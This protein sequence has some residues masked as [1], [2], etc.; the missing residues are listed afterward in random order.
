MEATT[1]PVLVLAGCCGK[2]ARVCGTITR[3]GSNAAAV[4]K[5]LHSI[6]W[7]LPN[8][9]SRCPI[10]HNADDHE[11]SHGGGVQHGPVGVEWTKN[12]TS[13]S[14]IAGPFGRRQDGRSSRLCPLEIS[15][16]LKVGFLKSWE[17]LI[18]L[19]SLRWLLVHCDGQ[20]HNL[21]FVFFQAGKFDFCLLRVCTMNSN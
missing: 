9:R 14:P 20:F 16:L 12:C 6:K 18:R 5:V 4:P 21:P 11:Q 7:G 15:I 8:S 10:H 1:A 2:F 13:A 17:D 19:R 3:T